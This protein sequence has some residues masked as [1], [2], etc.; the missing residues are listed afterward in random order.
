MPT[1]TSFQNLHPASPQGLSTVVSTMLRCRASRPRRT[2]LGRSRRKLG[3]RQRKPLYGAGHRVGVPLA[4]CPALDAWFCPIDERVVRAYSA[5]DLGVALCRRLTDYGC[6][7]MTTWLCGQVGTNICSD[8]AKLPAGSFPAGANHGHPPTKLTGL[9][10]IRA[11]LYIPNDVK[12]LLLCDS[13]RTGHPS[14]KI[15]GSMAGYSSPV[16]ILQGRHPEA[17]YID[18]TSNG[19]TLDDIVR[20]LQRI[21][22]ESRADYDHTLVITMLN[23]KT[24]QMV[25]ETSQTGV[26]ILQL[27]DVLKEHRRPLVVLGG[28]QQLWGFADP[29]NLF[30]QK[31]LLICQSQGI[32]A[33]DGVD[34]LSHIPKVPGDAYHIQNTWE[35]MM[36]AADLLE[37]AIHA[38]YAIVPHGSFATRQKVPSGLTAEAGV[39]ERASP[40]AH[41]SLPFPNEV[42]RRAAQLVSDGIKVPKDCTFDLSHFSAL[43]G[44]SVPHST[45]RFAAPRNSHTARVVAEIQALNDPGCPWRSMEPVHQISEALPRAADGTYFGHL[46]PPNALSQNS[47]MSGDNVSAAVAQPASS[48]TSVAY[49][50]P[51]TGAAPIHPTVGTGDDSAVPLTPTRLPPTPTDYMFSE[52]NVS[53]CTADVVFPP[54]RRLVYVTSLRPRFC[55]T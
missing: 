11:A 55:T 9:A 49:P 45:H 3:R 31:A 51:T 50:Q 54:C 41:A 52:S 7:I 12:T 25:R 5:G 22:A 42:Q 44:S 14:K 43:S 19:C 40:A 46:A 6:R 35:A 4:S 38:A 23:G 28:D 26:L 1:S 36:M 39:E 37:A 32:P 33:I 53:S 16:T 13:T 21:P 20:L 27:C 8:A 29:Y 15:P 24:K 18:W 47:V 48:S 17:V 2:L 10:S 34:F 30:V